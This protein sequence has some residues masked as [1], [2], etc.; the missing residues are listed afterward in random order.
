M[1]DIFCT[2]VYIYLYIIYRHTYI[3]TYF[4]WGGVGGGCSSLPSYCAH[5]EGPGDHCSWGPQPHPSRVFDSHPITACTP[6]VLLPAPYQCHEGRGASWPPPTFHPAAHCS[7]P[8]TGGSLALW[9]S[10][11]VV[12]RLWL[13]PAL[14]HVTVIRRS[15]R[16][17]ITKASAGTGGG[18]HCEL[19]KIKTK[20]LACYSIFLAGCSRPFQKGPT[21]LWP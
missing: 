5:T 2:G 21:A 15:V 1:A 4:F 11:E 3:Y 8:G 19:F 13:P 12:L 9:C 10:P 6:P 14:G 7:P 16:D 20:I 18:K 17:G